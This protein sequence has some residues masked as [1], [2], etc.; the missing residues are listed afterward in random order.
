MLL[1]VVLGAVVVRQLDQAVVI[2]QVGVGLAETPR[3]QK[4][5]DEKI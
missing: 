4:T 5:D 1:I 3:P 2:R